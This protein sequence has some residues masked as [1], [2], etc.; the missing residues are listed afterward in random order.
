MLHRYW[1]D[2]TDKSV[3]WLEDWLADAY[4]AALAGD[5]EGMERALSER[6]K[7]FFGGR[8]PLGIV[9]W[10]PILTN[11]AIR[12]LNH[13]PPT[14]MEDAFQVITSPIVANIAVNSQ[15][16]ITHHASRSLIY[17]SFDR[18]IVAEHVAMSSKALVKR[19][20]KVTLVHPA[21]AN[22]NADLEGVFRVEVGNGDS[23]CSG[24]SAF[25]KVKRWLQWRE[26]KEMAR[27]IAAWR[28]PVIYARQHWL[29][30]LPPLI[31]RR[32][33]IPYIAE[34][35]GLRYWGLWSQ[36]AKRDSIWKKI[37]ISNLERLCARLADAIISPSQGLAERLR[38]L[39]GNSAQ[40]FVV[41]NGVDH[42]VFRPL[43]KVEVRE[44][45]G[46]PKNL[47][48][49]V[50]AGSLHP[51]QGVDVL[52]HAFTL[53]NSQMPHC[54]LVVVGGQDE[55]DRE[56]YPQ[57]A[58]SLGIRHQVI[59]VPFVPYEQSALYIAA[60]D[61]CV[62]PY[63]PGCEGASPLKV[64]A[65]LSCGRPVVISDLRETA[66]LVRASGAGLLVPPGNPEA[67][68]EAL[69]QLLSDPVLC[70]EMGRRGREA[71]LNGYTWDHNAQRIEAILLRFLEPK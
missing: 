3:D 27:I 43:P 44:K 13:H 68:A 10:F 30:L 25:S 21:S 23:Q 53:L 4:C 71:I 65:Y 51:W 41:P 19:G 36:A 9:R 33:G 38:E 66:D 28:P 42:T 31:A 34:F 29:G 14:K 12:K 37:V 55:K 35:N 7:L 40:I 54:K 62:A 15:P 69:R 6:S 18:N 16:S 67:L 17:L 32:L 39:A 61:V 56:K 8:N 5:L 1:R 11:A 20:W 58:E 49:V 52:L 2:L 26:Q 46:L 60:A 59:F 64:F 50:Y 48:L 22:P 57:I 47:P 24:K 63:K 70:A 45:L